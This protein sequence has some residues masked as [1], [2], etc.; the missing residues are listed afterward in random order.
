M[1]DG[2]EEPSLEAQLAPV[3][4]ETSPHHQISR[5]VTTG[6]AMTRTLKL[7]TARFHANPR[8]SY[9]PG[10]CRAR[11][12]TCKV[13]KATAWRATEGGSSKIFGNPSCR[14]ALAR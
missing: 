11:A 3:G 6:R 12:S 14:S 8:R 13:A 4:V 9:Q 10:E 2:R 1:P 5:E 7:S